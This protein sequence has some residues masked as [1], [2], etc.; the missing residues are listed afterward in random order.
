MVETGSKD[1]RTRHRQEEQI[2]K[3]SGNVFADLGLSDADELAAKVDLARTIR[4]LVEKRG[5]SQR[6]AAPIVGVTQPELSHLWQRR[7]D[8]FS[9]ERLCRM[10]TAL[11]QDVRI[12]V[13]PKARSRRHATVRTMIRTSAARKSA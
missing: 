4:Q 6:E 12:V 2:T 3:S 1:R 13:Q 10:L 9:I 11:D 5:L 8:G 7:L